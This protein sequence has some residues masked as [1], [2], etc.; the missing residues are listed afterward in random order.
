MDTRQILPTF[1]DSTL[2]TNQN[3][4]DHYST[5]EEALQ[6]PVGY[7]K[8]IFNGQNIARLRA[9]L[10]EIYKEKFN[11]INK[12]IDNVCV[13]DAGESE[14]LS[15]YAAHKRAYLTDMQAKLFSDAE[16]QKQLLLEHYSEI[17]S[18]IQKEFA[19][20]DGCF[21][22]NHIRKL[23]TLKQNLVIALQQAAFFLHQKRADLKSKPNTFNTIFNNI[24]YI[25]EKGALGQ[26]QSAPSFFSAMSLNELQSKI[27]EL[28]NE[29]Q[30]HKKNKIHR[31]I[32]QTL[33]KFCANQIT[34]A[35]NG[36]AMM[37]MEKG[38][39]AFTPAA[40]DLEK[41]AQSSSEEAKMLFKSL[42]KDFA[43][44][45]SEFENVFANSTDYQNIRDITSS[46]QSSLIDINQ[47]IR[48]NK[49]LKEKLQ[50]DH[51]AVENLIF[52]LNDIAARG[53]EDNRPST[54]SMLKD[55]EYT[56][57]QKTRIIE[58]LQEVYENFHRDFYKKHNSDFIIKHLDALLSQLSGMIKILEQM[59]EEYITAFPPLEMQNNQLSQ[60]ESQRNQLMESLLQL[61]SQINEIDSA[62]SNI[63]KSF[64]ETRDELFDFLRDIKQNDW[65]TDLLQRLDATL[66]DVDD[67]TQ[68]YANHPNFRNTKLDGVIIELLTESR[69]RTLA[70]KE[71]VE[72]TFVPQAL[73]E[74]KPES[75]FDKNPKASKI[76]YAT[77]IGVGAALVCTLAVG[78]ILFT[79][80]AGLLALGAIAG[81]LAATAAATCAA[82]FFGGYAFLNKIKKM[83]DKTDQP[84]RT[85]SL[86]TTANAIKKFQGSGEK[87]EMISAE[88]E[89]KVKPAKPAAKRVSFAENLVE[90][91]S[92][93][94]RPA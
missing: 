56:E 68:K 21:Y 76:L 35:A 13:L 84:N 61:E 81:I 26:Y 58:G 53:I 19:A 5:V 14:N 62:Y 48:G 30:K 67:L 36:S 73:Q 88:P 17:I 43:G 11:V 80:G 3:L 33:E 10:D 55:F 75:F 15:Q 89:E 39:F 94:P 34:H 51:T 49:A 57:E 31:Q 82:G 29:S 1:F 66:L 32:R 23:D 18:N 42:K 24:S 41:S 7:L 44:K 85:K 65:S 90:Y 28:L 93:R 47:L 52:Q 60:I 74:P 86:S 20:Q 12:G 54:A 71:T 6:L 9:R 40:K 25:D 2:I 77:L 79:A 46:T 69:E 8:D 87:A 4:A 27:N 37:T 70:I 83:E 64:Q 45:T 59:Q 78:A 91:E 63:E 50:Q 22:G 38:V 92:S 72:P 16:A